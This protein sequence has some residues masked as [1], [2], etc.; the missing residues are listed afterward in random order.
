MDNRPRWPTP[1]ASPGSTVLPRLEDA[2]AHMHV[3][4]ACCSRARRPP[5]TTSS[6][7]STRRLHLIPRYRQKLAFAAAWRRAARCGSTTRTS[8]S[9][10]HVR[11]T[12]LPR[13]A[14]E[15]EL[16]ATRRARVRPAA[17]PRQA[18]VGAVARRALEGD[19]FAI[20]S[21][22][23]PR[24]RRRR[25]RRRH[26][27]GP[28]RPR[29]ASPHRPPSRRPRGCRGPSRAR[30]SCWPTRCSSA[31]TVAGRERPRA[32]ARI[33]ERRAG[34]S[35]RRPRRPRGVGA[36][37]GP[38]SARPPAPLQRA[39]R[40]APA[41]RLGRRRPRRS[42]RRS[43]TRSAARVNDVVLAAVTGAL[44]RLP[45]AARRRHRGHRAQGDGPVSVRADA[46]RGALGNRVAAM[47]APL[48]VGARPTR[49]SA[50]ARPRG[51]ERPQG[52]RP[53]RRRGAAHAARRLRAADDPRP[54]PRACSRAS[55]CSTSW[56]RT[57]PGPQFPLYLLGRRLLRLYPQVPL[58]Q[59]HGAGHRDHVLRRT[60]DFGLLGDFDA[61]PDLD[62]LAAALRD[63]IAEMAIAAGVPRGNGR[64]PRDTAGRARSR[65]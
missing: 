7:R 4:R 8:T 17:G 15:A 41:L 46:E 23:P 49:S 14:A 25:L 6:R 55:A 34:R 37:A 16:Q 47:Y 20:V 21:Q 10:Y 60:L 42:S 62:D 33:R 3:A 57:C 59:Q 45:A 48:P 22:D 39:D 63:A 50:S 64:A 19:R 26:R 2:G 43:R 35:A 31:R 27:D 56:S 24:A 32:C 65:R 36:L 9:R 54:R 5:T 18:A 28:V 52:V 61:M 44:A 12:A 51:D 38:A 1:T 30:R 29:A 11:H 58:A 53:G 13:P 40:A